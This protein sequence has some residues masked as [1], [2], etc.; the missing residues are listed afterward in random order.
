MGF[1]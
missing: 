1:D